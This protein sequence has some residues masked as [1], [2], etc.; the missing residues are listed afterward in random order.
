MAIN[1]IVALAGGVGGAK[2]AFGLARLLPAESLTV[3]VNTA[4]DLTLYGLAISPDLDTVMYTL[5]GIN[6]PATGWGLAGDSSQM[7]DMLTRY[8]EPLWFGLGD[9]DLATHLLRTR[10]LAEGLTLTEATARLAQGLGIIHTLLPMTDA[11][12]RTIVETVEQGRLGFQ[13]YFVKHRW[14][15]T[16]KSL[17]F[18]GTEAAQASPQVRAALESADA[19]V[20]CPSNPFLSVDPI[21]AVPGIRDL[22]AAKPVVAVSPIVGGSAIKGPAAKLLAEFGLP[23][24]AS[25]VMAYY[26]DLLAGFVADKRDEGAIEPAGDVALL[27]TDTIMQSDQDKIRLAG[28][29]LAWVEDRIL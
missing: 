22:L 24:S 16:V 20:I 17:S 29:V 2:L 19:V 21:L 18:E 4:D 28:D 7:L 11:P 14:Q 6:N 25:A 1:R 26:G 23:T 13:E 8:G 15:P 5:A 9:R 3:I 12:V 10:W 27:L